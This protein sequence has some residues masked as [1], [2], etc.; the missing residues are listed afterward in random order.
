M[1]EEQE[2]DVYAGNLDYREGKGWCAPDGTGT[3]EGDIDIN[4][5]RSL[6][7]E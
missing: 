6:E 1:T 5:V 4:V 2:K 7:E 3:S